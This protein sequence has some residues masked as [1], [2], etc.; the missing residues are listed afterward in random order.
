MQRDKMEQGAGQKSRFVPELVS[1]SEY[2]HNS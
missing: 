1:L 2:C